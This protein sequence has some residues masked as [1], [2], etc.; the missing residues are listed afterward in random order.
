MGFRIGLGESPVVALFRDVG[1]F[2]LLL[3]LLLL[4]FVVKRLT[5]VA[6]TPSLLVATADNLEVAFNGID[7]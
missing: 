4:L 5:F 6:T 2:M 1:D 3:L 7:E